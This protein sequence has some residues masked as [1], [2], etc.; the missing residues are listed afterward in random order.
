[1]DANGPSLTPLTPASS[2]P[3]GPGRGA[4]ASVISG[5]V[6]GVKKG[7]SA[8]TLEIQSPQGKIR[9]K[10]DGD[11]QVGDKVRMTFPGNGGVV[12]EKAGPE[13]EGTAD[14]PGAGYTLPRNLNA[15]KDLRA[16]EEQ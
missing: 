7:D 1:M 6:I 16:F 2:G 4:V 8:Q 5:T 13:A 14:G 3:T 11:F 10:A 15:V 12:L 9:F